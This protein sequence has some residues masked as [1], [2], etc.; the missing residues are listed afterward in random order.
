MKEYGHQENRMM[1]DRLEVNQAG[2]C[3][4]EILAM[5]VGTERDRV[6]KYDEKTWQITTVKSR[7]NRCMAL[8]GIGDG[9]TEWGDRLANSKIVLEQET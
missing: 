5:T 1:T 8:W 4:C 2:D 3:I 6:E 9:S 7:V